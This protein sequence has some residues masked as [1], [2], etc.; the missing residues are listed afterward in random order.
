MVGTSGAHARYRWIISVNED[1]ALMRIVKNLHLYIEGIGEEA[2]VAEL[3]R[4][5]G[6]G[7]MMPQYEK[8][9]RESSFWEDQANIVTSEI[10]E[11]PFWLVSVTGRSD[12]IDA[13]RLYRHFHAVG[14]KVCLYDP[15]M[16]AIYLH[17]DERKVA[18]RVAHL[19]YRE[20]GSDKVYHLYLASD[21]DTGSYY[22]ISRYG[23]RGTGLHKHE[24]QIGVSREE[25]EKDWERLYRSKLRKGYRIGREL[26]GRQLEM[27]VEATVSQE[28]TD[29]GFLF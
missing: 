5:L 17:F 8:V 18:L 27:D 11:I 29:N 21:P 14:L 28:E 1:G 6:K 20:D 26:R 3:D 25:A 2:I 24:K 4:F 12:E 22:L 23:R 15:A 13:Y 9:V 10:G 7:N 16:K 19:W